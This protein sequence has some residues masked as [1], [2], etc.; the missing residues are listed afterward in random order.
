MAAGAHII[1]TGPKRGQ[2]KPAHHTDAGTGHHDVIGTSAVAAH[3][4]VCS[5]QDTAMIP[6]L[7]NSSI[8]GDIF[9]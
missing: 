4:V 7:V 1:H 5:Q 9:P 2:D 3:L 6:K 8:V